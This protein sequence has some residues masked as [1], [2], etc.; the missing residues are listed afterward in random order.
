MMERYD[1]TYGNFNMY[2]LTNEFIIIYYN[3]NMDI[4]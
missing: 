4:L 1:Y 3:I 2:R